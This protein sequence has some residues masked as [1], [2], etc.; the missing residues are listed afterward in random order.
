MLRSKFVKFL[1]SILKRQDN[2]VSLFSFM[3][4]NSSV[5]FSSNN[6]HFVQKESIKAK[7]FETFECSG[8]NLSNS[9]RQFWNDKTIL[10]PSSVS[11]KIT[12]LYFLAQT[13]YTLFKRSLLKQKFLRLLSVQVKICQIHYVNLET[14]NWF[15]SKF[16]IPLQFYERQLLCTFFSS[17]NLYFAQ[18]EPIKMKI[19]KTF[20]FSKPQFLMS[21][22]E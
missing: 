7:I 2:F 6:I 21:T 12:P 22:L 15:L 17:N 19:F 10:C 20:E 14:T 3:K 18:K 11:W 1:T 9:W 5:L 4:D 13:I 8:Q 16:C